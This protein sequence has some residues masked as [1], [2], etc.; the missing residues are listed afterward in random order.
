M[1]TATLRGDTERATDMPAAAP[2]NVPDRDDCHVI[3][4]RFGTMEFA[5][6]QSLFMPRGILG[7]AEHKNFGLAHLP[8][9]FI[10]Q[11]ML[12]QSLSD[13][14]TSF[15]LLPLAIDAGVIEQDD[16]VGACNTMGVDPENAVVA[17]IVTIR[18][19]GGQPQVTVNLRAPV[20]FDSE[21]RT[22]WQYVLPDSRYQVRHVLNLSEPA[23]PA[24]D[25]G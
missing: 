3:D 8:N 15:L 16:L 23:A 24:A 6:E 22:G 7:F 14:E 20:M 25:V 19:V 11:L 5:K 4:T 17:V 2:D 21:T 10:D 12:L 13:P 9:R 1:T 18:D